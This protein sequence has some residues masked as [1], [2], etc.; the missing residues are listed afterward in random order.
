V[1]R[2]STGARISAYYLSREPMSASSPPLRPFGR[3]DVPA[4]TGPESAELDRRAI[5]DVGVSQ[6]VLMENAGRAAAAVLQR[7]YPKGRVV[8]LIG[9]GNNG[10]DALVVLRTL[11]SWGREARGILVADREADDPLLHGWDLPL[12]V[13][14]DL[15]DGAWQS[16]MA[17]SAVVVDGVLGTGIRGAPR[18]RQAEVIRRLSEAGRPVL[19]IDM[20]SGVDATTGAVPGEAVRADVTVAFGAPKLGTLFHPARAHTGRLVAAEIGFSPWESGDISALVATPDWARSRLPRRHTDTHKKAVGSVLIAAGGAGMA[21]AAIL[22]ARAAFRSG[23]GLV[24]I[25]SVPENRSAIQ[26]ALPEAIYVDASDAAAVEAAREESDAVAAGPGLGT[27]VAAVD[28]LSLVLEG[29]GRPTVLDADALN[30]AASGALNLLDIAERMPLLITPH[31]GEMARLLGPGDADP[32]TSAR[33][34]AERFSCSVLLKGAP[35][36]VSSPHGGLLVDT[37]TSS[38]MAVAGMGDALT[39]VCGSFM[40]QGLDPSTA[41]AVGLYCTGRSA[42]LAGR[43]AALTPSDVIRWLPHAI[44]EDAEGVSDLDLPFVIYDADRAR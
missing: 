38:D 35:S 28:L 37:Q 3:I 8:G 4:P 36:V 39:G 33:A 7:L 25:C 26:A 43:G 17:T 11:L 10:G 20:P 23:A 14:T 42:R 44:G 13:D 9:A 1:R 21:G 30:L 27:A 2:F 31:L 15:D 19:A 12:L 40:A 16:E 18:E 29:P 6:A 22:A 24:R 5:E 34:A 41:A 32:A